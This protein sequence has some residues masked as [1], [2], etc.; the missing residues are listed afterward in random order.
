[1]RGHPLMNSRRTARV[2]SEIA[3]LLP[4]FAAGAALATAVGW[5]LVDL[6]AKWLIGLAAAGLYVTYRTYRVYVGRIDAGQQHA[7]ELADLHLATIEA[8]ALAIDAKDRTCQ[9]H[10][11]RVQLYATSVARAMGMSA[12]DVQGVETAALLHDIGKLAVPEHIL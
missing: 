11:R 9:T 1:M 7:R 12:G 3:R 10:L 8:L 6:H 5:I 2:S 4:S